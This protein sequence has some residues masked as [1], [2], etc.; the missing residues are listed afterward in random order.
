VTAID[1][2]QFFNQWSPLTHILMQDPH[3]AEVRSQIRR[4]L[5]NGAYVRRLNYVNPKTPAQFAQDMTGYLTGGRCGSNY[6]DAILGSYKEHWWAIPRGGDTA[7]AYFQVR[8]VTDLNSLFHPEFLT[9]DRITS[10]D[11][12]HIAAGILALKVRASGLDPL[13]QGLDPIP[14][15]DLPWSAYSPQIQVFQWQEI[16]H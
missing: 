11:Q 16:I 13:V 6:A 9:G 2:Y 15:A 8:N 7:I 3:Q 5:K 14:L 1:H 10:V 12:Y 4:Y